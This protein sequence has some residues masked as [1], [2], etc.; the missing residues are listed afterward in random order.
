MQ[1]TY[2]ALS[3]SATLSIRDVTA[4]MGPFR[5]FGEWLLSLLPGNE[6]VAA[7]GRD[8]VDAEHLFLAARVHLKLRELPMF[9]SHAHLIPCVLTMVF[10][11]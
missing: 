1:D 4:L 2:I 7:D 9:S 10:F 3:V 5:R 8:L 11:P 6:A